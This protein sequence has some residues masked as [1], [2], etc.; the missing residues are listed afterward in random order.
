MNALTKRHV[1]EI[2]SPKRFESPFLETLTVGIQ[3]GWNTSFLDL[4][5]IKLYACLLYIRMFSIKFDFNGLYNSLRRPS[6]P[7][8]ISPTIGMNMLHIL[9]QKVLGVSRKVRWVLSYERVKKVGR[10]HHFMPSCAKVILCVPPS[11]S[12]PCDVL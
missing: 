2:N 1:R 5:L 6:L 11:Q 3:F 10:R 8:A 9:L 12:Y 4:A 7:N